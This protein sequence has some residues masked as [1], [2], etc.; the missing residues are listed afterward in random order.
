MTL[1]VSSPA[2]LALGA[3]KLLFYRWL[4]GQGLAALPFYADSAEASAGQALLGSAPAGAVSL[5]SGM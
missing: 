3:D 1:H 2:V 5:R 4:V